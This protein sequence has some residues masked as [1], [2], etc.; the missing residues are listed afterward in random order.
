[1]CTCSKQYKCPYGDKIREWSSSKMRQ[2]SN[3]AAQFCLVCLGKFN[4]YLQCSHDKNN[5]S[6][7]VFT[8]LTLQGTR[9]CMRRR[10]IGGYWFGS[11]GAWVLKVDMA[12]FLA[13]GLVI[14]VVGFE[15]SDE[16]LGLTNDLATYI[17]Y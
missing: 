7:Y 1:V 12:T 8:A 15:N 9:F 2:S 11:I 5:I 4:T 3:S 13:P 17:H 10:V 6:R 14:G 16:R